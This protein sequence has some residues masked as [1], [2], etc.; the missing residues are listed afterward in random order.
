[1]DAQNK[2]ILRDIIYMEIADCLA[3]LNAMEGFMAI[4]RGK[5]ARIQA[6]AE[7]AGVDG[8]SAIKDIP[9]ISIKN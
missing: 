7:V 2:K 1:M 4:V 5:K 8:K 3:I 6:L 9:E